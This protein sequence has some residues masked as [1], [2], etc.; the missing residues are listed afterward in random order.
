MGLVAAAAAL[1]VLN[2]VPVR[3]LYSVDY[4]RNFFPGSCDPDNARLGVI[5][6]DPVI[7]YSPVGVAG[8]I[9]SIPF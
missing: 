2:W 5:Q 8:A 9:G 7:R 3:V 1:A 6:A 4:T